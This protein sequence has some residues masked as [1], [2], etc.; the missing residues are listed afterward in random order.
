MASKMPAARDAGN[1]LIGIPAAQQNKYIKPLRCEFCEAHVSFVNGFTRTLGED[2]V[3]VDPFFRLIKGQ[4]HSDS[5][6]YNVRG[7]VSIIARESDGDILAAIHGNQYELRLLAIK[8][9]L[10]QLRES[11][12][13]SGSF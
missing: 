2:V 4:L 11:V 10:E 3:V 6:T 12:V 5:C 8:Q 7:Q 9:T 1:V 13:R